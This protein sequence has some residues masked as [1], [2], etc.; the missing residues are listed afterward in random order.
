MYQNNLNI[1]NSIKENYD[2]IIFD[3]DGTLGLIKLNWDNF[4][5]LLLNE[6]P[7][8]FKTPKDTGLTNVI[9]I[10]DSQ[11]QKTLWERYLELLHTFECNALIEPNFF[12]IKLFN[13]FASEKKRVSIVSN[14]LTNTILSFCKRFN[15]PIS[16]Y[17]IIGLDISYYPKPHPKGIYLALEKMGI[18]QKKALIIGDSEKDK[19]AASL[20]NI[21][22][23]NINK[24]KLN[25][26][27]N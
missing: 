1:L 20:A 3:F 21:D 7:N 11:N 22:F 13:I 14:N 25:Y 5:N 27:E 15:L 17:N 8:F 26:D 19:M 24:L 2:G 6:F 4:K 23:I 9:N 18:N 12:G 16:K 10:R